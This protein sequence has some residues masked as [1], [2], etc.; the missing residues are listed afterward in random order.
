M[1]RFEVQRDLR[2]NRIA[3]KAGLT[4]NGVGMKVELKDAVTEATLSY[5]FAFSSNY[6]WTLGGKL[7]GLSSTSKQYCPLNSA[8]MITATPQRQVSVPFHS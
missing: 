4:D 2:T 3:G 6:D 7:P 8:C 1:Q 5:R